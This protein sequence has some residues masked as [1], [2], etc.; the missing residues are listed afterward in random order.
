MS[1]LRR[2]LGCAGSQ[3]LSV[4]ALRPRSESPTT[5]GSSVWPTSWRRFAR[6][7]RRSAAARDAFFQ[8][9]L[10]AGPAARLRDFVALLPKGTRAAFEFRHASW[11]HDDVYR[12][13]RRARCALCVADTDDLETRSSPPLPMGVTGCCV[14]HYTA[15]RLSRWAA[16]IRQAGHTFPRVTRVYFKH[17]DCGLGTRF[18]RQLLA[19]L[20]AQPPLEP[21]RRMLRRRCSHRAKSG[22]LDTADGSLRNSSSRRWPLP[23]CARSASAGRPPPSSWSCASSIRRVRGTPTSRRSESRPDGLAR[24]ERALRGQPRQQLPREPGASPRSSCLKYTYTSP[25]WPAWRIRA[26][27]R[28]SLAAV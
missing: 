17:E 20:T 27:Q 22:F 13:P 14:N 21:E 12:I 26:A 6:L 7:P 10:E 1:P 19:R 2:A 25:V 23:C 11:F 15:A 5:S 8:L 4:L 3:G 24:F 18:A 9:Q 28:D 16:R